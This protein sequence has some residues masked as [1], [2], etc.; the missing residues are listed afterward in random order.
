MKKI[1]FLF[2]FA[3]PFITQSQILNIERVR[4]E[5]D[6]AKVFMLKT[7]AGLSIFNRSA[8][9]DVP[10][11]MLGTNFDVNAIYYPGNHAYM[12]I[13]KFDYLMVN[14]E[15]VLNFGYVHGR[16]NFMRER[17]I[18]FETYLQYS[19]DNF[20]GLDPRWIAGGGIRHNIIK[21]EK[22][23]FLIGVGG[24]YEYE[25][26]QHPFSEEF[27]EVSLVKSSNYLSF[28]LTLNEFVDLNTVS[29]Y[30]VGYDSGISGFRNRIS[31]ST[32][33]NTKLTDRFSL[34][35]SFEL[36]Y[37]DKPVVPITKLIYSFKTGLAIDF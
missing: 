34:T 11:N 28:Q 31:N 15:D 21:S 17:K 3:F 29:Y 13:S 14:E 35:N 24:L 16:I 20:R 5:R 19:Y 4:L 6:T 8:A 18:N 25:K 2:F 27:V 12:F 36:S 7:N 22:V 37:E 26:W 1:I 10:V 30:Q 9:A 32:I 33:L 23:T